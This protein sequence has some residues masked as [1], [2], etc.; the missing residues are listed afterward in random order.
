LGKQF[1]KYQFQNKVGLASGV[2][3]SKNTFV[4]NKYTEIVHGKRMSRELNWAKVMV[5]EVHVAIKGC[6]N[7]SH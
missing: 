7:S 4:G 5:I 1:Q 3:E 2:L 6:L